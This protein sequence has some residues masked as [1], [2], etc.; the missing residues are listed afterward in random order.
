MSQTD[1][2]SGE[3]TSTPSN[4]GLERDGTLRTLWEEV[5]RLAF[6]GEGN[7]RSDRFGKR[8]SWAMIETW[9]VG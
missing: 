5:F 1:R 2:P 6:N 7:G 4:L 9:K 3:D 8:P